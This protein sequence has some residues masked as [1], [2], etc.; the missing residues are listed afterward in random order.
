MP[1]A[2]A[3]GGMLGPALIYLCADDRVRPAGPRARAGRS[4]APPT[5]R[6]A[7]SPRASSLGR[8]IR[9]FRSC[10]SSRSPT[11][12]WGCSIIAAFYPT[13]PLRI[14]RV[15]GAPRR[16]RCSS[17][18]AEEARHAKLLAL[19]ARCR[20]RCRGLAFYR[21][22]LHPALALVPIM[23]FLPHAAR[24]PGPVRRTRRRLTTR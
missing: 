9:P 10:C 22:G 13:G 5:S 8:S 14:D 23:P 18:V 6:S 7:T 20:R 1:L 16:R 4:R 2:A 21:G 19:R 24:D 17:P 15:R 12:R 11:T 3:I